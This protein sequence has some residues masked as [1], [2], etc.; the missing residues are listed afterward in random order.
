MA[1]FPPCQLSGFALPTECFSVLCTLRVRLPRVSY[2][3]R[4]AQVGLFIPPFFH[5]TFIEELL[6]ARPCL[7]RGQP[8]EP[9][10]VRQSAFHPEIRLI[11]TL[12]A[13]IRTLV[14]GLSFRPEGEERAERRP[15]G[16]FPVG[17]GAVWKKGCSAPV[18][19]ALLYLCSAVLLFRVL[20]AREWR[21]RGRVQ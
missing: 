4:L 7:G 15:E 12:T 11:L 21:G 3:W 13:G 2:T 8:S 18:Y 1:G 10:Q 19:R 14:P 17:T 20:Q 9:G 6:Q 16:P 5:Q